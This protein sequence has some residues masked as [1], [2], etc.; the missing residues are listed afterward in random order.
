[1]PLWFVTELLYNPMMG[2]SQLGDPRSHW[3]RMIALNIALFLAGGWL[4]RIR[5]V[6]AE[7]V[8]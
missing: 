4:V 8:A 5:L 6:T 1:M 7:A 3:P 2:L